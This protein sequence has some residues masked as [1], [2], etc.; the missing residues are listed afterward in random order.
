MKQPRSAPNGNG[1]QLTRDEVRAQFTTVTDTLKNLVTGLG[2]LERDKNAWNTFAVA[3]F[4]NRE[5]LEAM[6]R[7]DW[8][9]RKIVNIPAYDATREWREW[10]AAD[11][12]IQDLEAEEKR[13]DVKRKVRSALVKARL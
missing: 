2:T 5:Q 3:G 1:K 8:V 13:L 11:K 4:V 10:Q 9:S 12:Q 6:Y 7:G